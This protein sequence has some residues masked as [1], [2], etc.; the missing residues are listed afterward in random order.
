LL[1][2]LVLGACVSPGKPG[3]RISS[4]Q[5]NV[6]FGLAD[7]KA[8]SAPAAVRPPAVPG[9]PAPTTGSFSG[10]IKS[11]GSFSGGGGDLSCPAA[12][13]TAFPE[14]PADVHVIGLPKEGVYRYKRVVGVTPPGGKVAT[15]TT[16]EDHT[17][18]DVKR[19]NDHLFTMVVE[20]PGLFVPDELVRTTFTV[21]TNPKLLTHQQDG[22]STVG[23]VPV[24]GYDVPVSEP[25]DEAGVFFVSS[26]H[27]DPKTRNSKGS[28]TPLVAVKYLPLNEGIVSQGDT[29]QSVGLDAVSGTVLVHQGTVTFR[30]RIDA[31]GDIVEGWLVE[32][33]QTYNNFPETQYLYTIATQ[34]GGLFI[35]ETARV[36]DAN[37]TAAQ[38]TVTLADPTPKPLPASTTTT[39]GGI[40]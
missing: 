6:V 24:P 31:C 11:S 27:L 10:T 20:Q 7:K 40:G 22:G 36:T 3:V 8:S 26:E 29:F 12:A 14:L 39:T 9:A 4:L 19:V 1:A 35:G 21:N 5:A 2:A 37:G 15:R 23:V 28:F 16:F 32:S 34:Y 30:N 33:T 13:L 38:V 17:V 25:G 18:S